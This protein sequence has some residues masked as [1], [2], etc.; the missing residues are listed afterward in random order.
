MFQRHR[1][2]FFDSDFKFFDDSSEF[3]VTS[4]CVVFFSSMFM[5]ALSDVMGISKQLSQATL[6]L[7][8]LHEIW[9]VDSQE[10]Y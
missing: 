10:D 7:E 2:L 6:N 9:S 4:L 1:N 8:I 5:S 3:S